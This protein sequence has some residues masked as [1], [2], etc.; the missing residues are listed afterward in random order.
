MQRLKDY[1]IDHVLLIMKTE[2]DAGRT[3]KVAD[4]N[5]FFDYVKNKF[6]LCYIMRFKTSIPSRALNVSMVLCG[7]NDEISLK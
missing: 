2:S 1:N 6:K 3:L 7:D 4:C 5:N